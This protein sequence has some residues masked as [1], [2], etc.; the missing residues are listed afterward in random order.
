MAVEDHDEGLVGYR[1]QGG[2][3]WG[4]VQRDA[5]PDFVGVD[6]RCSLVTVGT[7]REGREAVVVPRCDECRLLFR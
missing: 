5:V 7:G 3:G 2:R 4:Q 6:A 1:A